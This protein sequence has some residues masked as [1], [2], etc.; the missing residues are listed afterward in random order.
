MT[1]NLGSEIIRDNYEK[2]DI[3]NRDI[4]MD[5]TRD[6][7][8]G[9]LKRSLKPEFLNRIDETILFTPLEK[10]DIVK[11]V[12]LHFTALQEVLG[13]KNIRLTATDEVLAM[14]A[15]LGFDPQF[16]ARPV[17]RV[18]Q[19]KVLNEL[20]RQLLAGKVQEGQDL[21]LDEFDGAFVF[22]N[23]IRDEEKKKLEAVNNS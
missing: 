15:D 9:L 14:L 5:E 17:K 18:M 16:G 11:I 3:A 19:R 7:V 23:P 8:F 1:S 6:A 10:A 21:V 13:E 20:S 12:K 4:L 22:R 2:A